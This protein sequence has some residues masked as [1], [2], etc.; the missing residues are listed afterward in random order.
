MSTNLSQHLVCWIDPLSARMWLFHTKGQLLMLTVP[1]RSAYSH[2]QGLRISDVMAICNPKTRHLLCKASG[3][4]FPA[5][6]LSGPTSN[7]QKIVFPTRK[8]SE[9]SQSLFIQLMPKHPIWQRLLKYCCFLWITEYLHYWRNV[10]RYVR[11][12]LG[13]N[14]AD[15]D[16]TWSKVKQAAL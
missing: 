1:F 13:N 3:P 16:V 2:S 9:C 8:T 10:F 12:A 4:S 6:Q 15:T 11:E 14:N 7:Q 5:P